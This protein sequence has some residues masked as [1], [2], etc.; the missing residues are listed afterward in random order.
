MKKNVKDYY[1]ECRIKYNRVYLDGIGKV[2]DV[3]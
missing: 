2:T 3:I 1:I